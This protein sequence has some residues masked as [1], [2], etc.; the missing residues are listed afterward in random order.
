[1]VVTGGFSSSSLSSDVSRWTGRW[2]I[3]LKKEE[4]RVTV[5]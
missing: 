1:M 5:L 4:L 2:G 3:F